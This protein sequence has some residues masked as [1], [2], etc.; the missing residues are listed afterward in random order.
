MADRILDGGEVLV[1]VL[2]NHGVEYIFASPG[3]EWP[4]LWRRSAAAR[5]KAIP[6]R[7]TSHAV[8]NP[9]PS[10]QRELIGAPPVSCPP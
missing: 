9:S 7:D 8:T 10:V 4:P 1:E 6:R 2:N 5:P 3:S